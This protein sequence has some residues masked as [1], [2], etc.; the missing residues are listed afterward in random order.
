MEFSGPAAPNIP[1]LMCLLRFCG[2]AGK[3]VY[4]LN[5]AKFYTITDFQGDSGAWQV[6]KTGE[7][8]FLRVLRRIVFRSKCAR[9][10]VAICILKLWGV[11]SERFGP[12]FIGVG[13]EGV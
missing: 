13:R 7:M 12:A 3:V 8:T 6:G 11:N 1:F 10:V 5:Y 9:D 2:S 4:S